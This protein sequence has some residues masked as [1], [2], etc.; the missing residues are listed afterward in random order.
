[1]DAGN[2]SATIGDGDRQA[3]AATDPIEFFSLLTDA[4]EIPLNRATCRTPLPAANACL[5]LII[6]AL[7]IG[8]LPNLTDSARAAA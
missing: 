4:A 6:L 1:M 7:A 5:A 2:R 3:V 8:G